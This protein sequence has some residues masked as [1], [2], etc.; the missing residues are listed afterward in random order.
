L[1]LRAE[2]GQTAVEFTVV[3]VT[4]IMLVFGVLQAGV[5][6]FDS[7]TLEQATRDGARKAQINRSEPAAQ[8]I[9]DATAAVRSTASS[10]TQG[11]LTVTVTPGDNPQSP[12]G[13]MWEQNDLV[14]VAATYP[15]SISILGIVVASGT[16]S[17]STTLRME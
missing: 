15:W 6:Y 16:L 10:F 3:C 12:N 11:N 8:I 5:A 14:T 1:R 7:V 4:F 9:T 13:V 17:S 2:R